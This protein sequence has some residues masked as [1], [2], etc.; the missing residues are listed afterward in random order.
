MRNRLMPYACN[1]DANKP[2]HTPNL[3]SAFVVR[4]LH[5]RKYNTSSCYSKFQDQLA[6]VSEQ[7]GLSH[8]WLKTPEQ[9]FS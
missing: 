2:A 1:E 7:A 5:C 3:I 8:T 9:V 4:C 6:Y